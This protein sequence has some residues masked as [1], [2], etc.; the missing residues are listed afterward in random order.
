MSNII[1]DLSKSIA[2]EIIERPNFEVEEISTI[3][4][5]RIKDSLMDILLENV[6][7]EEAKYMKLLIEQS[8]LRVGSRDYVK[9]GY[10]LSIA[11]HK[12]SIAN[13]AVHNQRKINKLNVALEYIKDN[14]KEVNIEDLKNFLNES[15]V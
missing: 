5:V 9:L 4:M 11:K 10:K 12:K 2:R 8:K 15:E 1:E 6:Q 13:R 7:K 14:Y 3:I